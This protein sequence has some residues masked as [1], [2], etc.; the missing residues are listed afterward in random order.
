MIRSY[1]KIGF[2][3]DN[4]IPSLWGIVRR[5]CGFTS[6][7]HGLASDSPSGFMRFGWI[8]DR[9][10]RSESD[11]HYELFRPFRH[12][13]AVV[14]LKSMGKSCLAMARR[15]KRQGV[16]IVF[17]AN[18]DYLTPAEGT[19]YYRGMAPT[20]AQRQDMLS[21]LEVADCVIGDSEHIVS[22]CQAVHARVGWIPDNVLLDL[23]PS[24]CQRPS[25]PKK[26]LLWSGISFKAVDLLLIAPVLR[27]NAPR[28]RLVLV[29]DGWSGIERCYEPYRGQIM[30]LLSGIEHEIVPFRSIEQ[31]LSVYTDGD[32]FISPRFLDNTYNLGHTEW[33]ITL[34]M[35]CKRFV[36]ASPLPSYVTVYERSN[37]KGLRICRDL[38][39]WSREIESL[40]RNHVDLEGE[41][42]S[43]RRIIE[44]YYSTVEVARQHAQLMR[45]VLG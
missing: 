16:K 40:L 43:G 3:I 21:M 27:A 4:R 15:L 42:R 30:D 8:A 41:G 36:L 13:D 12:Y 17:D 2:V 9:V 33:K 39:D 22:R 5:E 31:L 11:L 37:G 45:Q 38:D 44:T 1:F 18:V 32:M 34:P 19:F 7:L 24:R 28:L 14:F 35:A 20:E 6:L 29:T 10:N 25:R 23:I 26:T